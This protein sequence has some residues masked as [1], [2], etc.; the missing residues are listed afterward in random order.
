MTLPSSSIQRGLME[1]DF[2]KDPRG[3]FGGSSRGQHTPYDGTPSGTLM[4][5]G[6]Y[7]GNRL[8]DD[9]TLLAAVREALSQQLAAQRTTQA[10]SNGLA[11]FDEATIVMAVRQALAE[12]G[13]NAGHSPTSEH[14]PFAGPEESTMIAALKS[15][16]NSAAASP[17]SSRPSPTSPTA[18][19]GDD[20]L[21][22]AAARNR[23]ATGT[24]AQTVHTEE[25]ALLMAI[26]EVVA[27]ANGGVRPPPRAVR[28]GPLRVR[29]DEDGGAIAMAPVAAAPEE[30]V[31]PPM[32]NPQWE[33]QRRER[34]DSVDGAQ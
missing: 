33:N 15:G 27:Q 18:L 26:K 5:T 8:P 2:T 10:A 20:A 16:N 1:N 9:G 4:S 12:S 3:S 32:Y 22:A 7:F 30:E 29:H 6:D 21:A 25:K 28:R 11:T 17:T 13:S 19:M 23:S 14:S 31:L 34:Q 24:M